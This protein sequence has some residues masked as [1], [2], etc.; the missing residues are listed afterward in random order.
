VSQ[1]LWRYAPASPPPPPRS[2]PAIYPLQGA[3]PAAV[4]TDPQGN[5]YVV[6][7]T[8]STNFPVT[9]N[10]LQPTLGGG[11]D[12]FISKFSPAGD[13]VWSTYFGGSG[14]DSAAGVAIDS[15]GNI[16]VAGTTS[17]PTCPC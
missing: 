16:L 4:A 9:A 8:S 7:Q 13:L 6:G 14:N 1:S 2:F 11:S 17:S 3:T 5:I 10:A 15:A 12:A